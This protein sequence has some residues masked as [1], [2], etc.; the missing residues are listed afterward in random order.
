[1]S[2]DFTG[3]GRSPARVDPHV[4]ADAPARLLE[5]LQERPDAGLKFRIVRSRGQENADETHPL[6]LLRVRS[7][8]P[9]RR[10]A[11]QRDE[12]PALHSITSSARAMS[13]GGIS[14]PSALA[15]WRLMVKLNLVERS[16]GRSAALAPL[17]ILSTKAAAR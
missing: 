11:E 1:M 16:I 7:E 5:T 4:A 14:R 10:A 3:I 13:V 12:L 8:R 15:V 2:A 17:S 9:R 6:A